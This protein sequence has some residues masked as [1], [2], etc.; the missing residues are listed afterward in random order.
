MRKGMWREVLGKWQ[1]YEWMSERR[2]KVSFSFSFLFFQKG[3]FW[4]K[5]L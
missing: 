1:S 5:R 2:G 3:S 4:S